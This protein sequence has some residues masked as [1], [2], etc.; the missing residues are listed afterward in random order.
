[1]R[2]NAKAH[3]TAWLPSS[4]GPASPKSD[5]GYGCWGDIADDAAAIGQRAS[6][7]DDR[8]RF[9]VGFGRRSV[10]RA[11]G[12]AEQPGPHVLVRRRPRIGVGLGNRRGQGLRLGYVVFLVSGAGF[13]MR[14]A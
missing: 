14:R 12:E 6:P 11:I 3:C 10:E 8:Q 9:L 4:E 2:C 1:M 5:T 13:A 7:P